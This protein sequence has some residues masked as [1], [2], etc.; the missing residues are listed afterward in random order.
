MKIILTFDIGII[1]Q[2]CGF[3]KKMLLSW[4]TFIFKI[5][6]LAF[7][8]IM[9]KSNLQFVVNRYKNPNL[10]QILSCFYC[11]SIIHNCRH[12]FFGL[13]CIRWRVAWGSLKTVEPVLRIRI[14]F[15]KI[16]PESGKLEPR[17]FHWRVQIWKQVSGRLRI[18]I[19]LKVRIRI[20]INVMQICNTAGNLLY[21]TR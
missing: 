21:V 16:D 15:R 11:S 6:L 5:E 9:M 7:L 17:S 20:R 3:T 10:G 2:N 18:R 1:F 4:W 12:T 13:Y 19:K 8:P 14:I